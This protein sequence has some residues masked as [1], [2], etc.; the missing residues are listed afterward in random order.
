VPVPAGAS[1]GVEVRADVRLRRRW[2]TAAARWD[3]LS[4]RG[5]LL[6]ARGLGDIRARIAPD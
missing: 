5:E 2:D 3:R 4:G 1:A 6:V